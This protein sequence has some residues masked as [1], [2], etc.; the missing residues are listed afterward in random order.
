M[1]HKLHFNTKMTSLVT[2]FYCYPQ[3]PGFSLLL[4]L[5]PRFVLLLN[6]DKVHG[7]G[8]SGPGPSVRPSCTT[9]P[10]LTTI[11]G[12]VRTL[13]RDRVPFSRALVY[14]VQ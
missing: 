6:W 13:A 8:L 11:V 14:Y 4:L 9:R 2:T 12:L 7:V 1:A 5:L 3:P 10:I